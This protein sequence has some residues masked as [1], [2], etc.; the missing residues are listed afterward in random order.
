[1]K[2]RGICLLWTLLCQS[3]FTWLYILLP[4]I[5]WNV[6]Y[7]IL[8]IHY[9]LCSQGRTGV[10]VCCYMLHSKQFPTA[11]EALNYYGQMRTHDRKV[12]IGWSMT[13]E[14]SY[15]LVHYQ[16]LAYFFPLKSR[17]I[18]LPCY[19]FPLSAFEPLNQFSWNFVYTNFWG[20]KNTS[21]I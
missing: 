10:M 14:M 8:I 3:L 17:L 1:M 2:F 7:V 9:F 18:R 4:L 5:I 19:V 11:N 20:G 16:F 13:I 15:S 12:R 6:A 21:A